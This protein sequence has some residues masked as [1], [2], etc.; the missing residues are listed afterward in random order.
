MTKPQAAGQDTAEDYRQSHQQRGGTYDATLAASPFDAYM[1]QFE[2]EYLIDV[3]PRL[4]PG[5]RPR[6]LDFACGTGR[7][8]ETVAPLCAETVGVDISPSMLAEARSKCPTV[9]FIEAD[10]TTSEI[11]LGT[12]D[13]AT[14]FRFFGNAQQELRVA[15]LQAL[16]RVLR[17]KAY[18]II[19]SHRNPQAISSLLNA[20][21]GGDNKGMDLHY[22]KLRKLLR[23]CGFQ[24]IHSRPVGV[25]MYRHKL[26]QFADLAATGSRR[27]ESIFKLPIFTPVAPDAVVIARKLR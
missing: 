6:C 16:H 21:T 7:I 19:N 2:R 26:M 10:L 24:I 3:I 1:A 17:P 13:L 27:R 22:F 25:W 23:D 15:V 9:N 14:S 4:F 12:F 5:A 8:S 11:D 20:A 18:L